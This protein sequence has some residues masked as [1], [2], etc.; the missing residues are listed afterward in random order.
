MCG[1]AGMSMSPASEVNTRELAHN[2][3]TAIQTRGTHSSG[4][5]FAKGN[6]AGV[7]K[8]AKPGSEL[9]LTDLPR[10]AEAV[11]LH[12]RFA[13]QGS[14]A[15]NR[16]NHPVVSPSGKIALVHN[17][18]ISNDYEF[19]GGPDGFENLPEVD[20]AVIPALIERDGVKAGVAQIEGYA[21]I[22]WLDTSDPDSKLHLARLDFSPVAFTWLLDGS[23]VF[24]ST[25]PLLAG[26]LAMSGLD[27]GH[28]FE[29][30]EENY[31]QISGGIIMNS[32]E[33]VA[34]Q[35]DSWARY[36]FAS[37][38]A[39]GHGSESTT[40]VYG[41]GIGS[42]FGNLAFDSDDE[43]NDDELSADEDAAIRAGNWESDYRSKVTTDPDEIAMAMSPETNKRQVWLPNPD[44][45][46]LELAFEEST[47]PDLKGF[48]VELEDNTIEFYETL[49]E[50]EDGLSFLANMSLWEGAPFP[51]ASNRLR[52]TNFVVDMGQVTESRGMESWLVD[53]GMI[54]EHESRGVYNLG[55]VRE[56]LSDIVTMLSI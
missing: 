5:A 30:P 47:E 33:E 39:G 45:G 24:A 43:F 16:N 37:A 32:M 29:M 36:K 56:G 31:L 44:T 55:Y 28:I 27:H 6:E 25:K 19:R 23:F 26:A 2:L 48:Y 21:A 8:K 54:D 51:T 35:E 10:R 4:F 40:N 14:A 7:Y 34:M 41:R 17:G 18:V 12:T 53:L 11:V 20:T 13:T 38:T 22:A 42:S 15:D 52:W 46:E 1:I 49:Q 9:P 3:L 50:L